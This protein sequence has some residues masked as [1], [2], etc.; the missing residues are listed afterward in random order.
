MANPQKKIDK[1]N[2]HIITLEKRRRDA[3]TGKASGEDEI[4]H[5]GIQ[6]QIEDARAK[7]LDLHKQRK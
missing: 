4:D 7:V 1:L 6:K 5:A 3:L 2:H